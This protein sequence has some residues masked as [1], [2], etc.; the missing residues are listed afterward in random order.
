[1]SSWMKYSPCE[2]IKKVRIPTLIVQ[3][4]TDFQVQTSEGQELKAC[5]PGAQLALIAGMNH[6]LKTAPEDINQNRLP[7]RNHPYPLYPSW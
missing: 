4:T 6:V 3:G 1:M 2:E 7:I 5:K